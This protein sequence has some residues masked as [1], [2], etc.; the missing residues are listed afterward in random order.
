MSD[1]AHPLYVQIA[2]RLREQIV[3]GCYPVGAA[4]PTEAELSEIFS[5][6]RNT[7]RE[8]LRRLVEQ[9]LIRRRQGS[10]SV[11][12]STAP[13]ATYVQ[14]FATLED[15]FANATTT[16]FAI[17]AVTP[18]ALEQEIADRIGGTYG[19]DWLLITGMRWTEPGGVPLAYVESYVPAEFAGV[20]DG[21]WN[22]R[23]PF[24]SL[25]QEASGR[26]ITEVFQEIRALE[27]P[28]NIAGTFGLEDGSW[29]LQLLRRYVT[30]EG[31]LIA[32]F[33]WHRADQFVYRMN[34]LRRSAAD[35]GGS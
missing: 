4:L 10:G 29:S 12:V 20:V 28:R 22:V 5:T 16:H 2:A 25:L 17:H 11:V 34:L 27:M 21:F 26:M 14:S 7:V 32:S 6:S 15:L 30:R 18:V 13:V 1:Q 33:N 35:A 3:D 8:A 31:T 23:L 24:Y 9:G 19:S